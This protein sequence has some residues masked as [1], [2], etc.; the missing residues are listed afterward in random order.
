MSAYNR[1]SRRDK[2]VFRQTA[3]KTKR[4]NLGVTNYRGG[5]RL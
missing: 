3:Q 1:S 5:I 2:A 4:I